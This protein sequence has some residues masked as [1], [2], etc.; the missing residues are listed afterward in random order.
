MLRLALIEPFAPKD[1]SFEK[2][3]FGRRAPRKDALA[4]P[5]APGFRS[6]PVDRSKIVG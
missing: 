3:R 6:F 5:G 2:G 1:G 4:Q